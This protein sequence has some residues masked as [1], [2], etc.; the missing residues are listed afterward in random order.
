MTALLLG[1][2]AFLLAMIGYALLRPT[3]TEPTTKCR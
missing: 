2:G 3:R 1:V